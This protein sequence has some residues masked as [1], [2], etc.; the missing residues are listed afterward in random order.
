MVNTK[1]IQSSLVLHSDLSSLQDGVNCINI[2]SRGETELG[3]Q[4]SNFAHLPFEFEGEKFQSVEGWYYWYSCGQ[5]PILKFLHGSEAKR[6]GESLQKEKEIGS[7]L[8][9]KIFYAKLNTYSDLKEKV[10]S[11]FLPFVHYYVMHGK[12]IL[13]SSHWTGE[14]W[15]VIREEIR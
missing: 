3:R 4:L 9:K 10:K 11:S 2:F 14:L 5:E 1:L 13:P 12:R 15:N 8:L 7:E 6:V